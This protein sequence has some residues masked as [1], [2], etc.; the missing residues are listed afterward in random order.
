MV[1]LAGY[2]PRPCSTHGA[3]WQASLD[4]ARVPAEQIIQYYGNSSS[5]I[6]FPF[7]YNMPTF[8]LYCTYFGYNVNSYT[9]EKLQ[10]RQLCARV[11]HFSAF[12][13][14]CTLFK[15]HVFLVCNYVENCGIIS[16]DFTGCF[17]GVMSGYYSIHI[18]IFK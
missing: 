7:I 6:I 4:T 15:K 18:G 17:V 14:T 1:G 8:Q 2:E 5:Y 16:R 12:H 11:M 10:Q 13:F 9:L 3:A